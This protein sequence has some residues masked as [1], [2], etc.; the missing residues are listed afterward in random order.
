MTAFQEELQTFNRGK[1]GFVEKTQFLARADL[2][3]FENEK[4]LR[5]NARRK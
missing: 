5:A 3:E 4:S 2:R 1:H